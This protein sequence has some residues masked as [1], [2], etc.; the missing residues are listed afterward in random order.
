MAADDAS[1]LSCRHFH[2]CDDACTIHAKIINKTVYQGAPGIVV[3]GRG[4]PLPTVVM[5]TTTVGANPTLV[6][7]VIVT[8]FPAGPVLVTVRCLFYSITLH[9]R[10]LFRYMTSLG[11]IPECV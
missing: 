3:R 6:P 9:G 7:F 4:I 8:R 10:E 2:L 5:P 11:L 1:I